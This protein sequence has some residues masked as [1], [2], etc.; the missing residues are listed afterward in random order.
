MRE[1]VAVLVVNA[2]VIVEPRKAHPGAP[3]LRARMRSSQIQVLVDYWL[4]VCHPAANVLTVT[5]EHALHCLTRVRSL[6]A[7]K[8]LNEPLELDA[9]D[10]DDEDDELLLLLPSGVGSYA[11]QVPSKSWS[12]RVESLSHGPASGSAP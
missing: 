10:A 9:E 11:S 5:G 6:L 3:V 8:H 4:V 2:G 12:A 1:Q 7:I